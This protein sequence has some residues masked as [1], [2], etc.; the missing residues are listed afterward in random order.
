MILKKIGVLSL[1]Y[2]M[3][4]LYGLVALI[5][6]IV[7]YVSYSSVSIGATDAVST[8]MSTLGI[9]IIPLAFIL[10]IIG[11]FIGGIV[12]ALVYNYIV[13]KITGG[14]KLELK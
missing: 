9:W 6:S 8:A 11:G 7:T 3:A 10:G 14:I 1:G 4:I 13:A 12:L 5:N 2:A